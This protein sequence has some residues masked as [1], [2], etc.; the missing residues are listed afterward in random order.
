MRNN[1][2]P[3]LKK[4]TG[5]KEHP[6]E[7]KEEEMLLLKENE[8]YPILLSPQY[9]LQEIPFATKDMYVRKTVHD[10]LFMASSK[11]PKGYQLVI[12]DTWR[13]VEVQQSLFDH[14]YRIFQ[15][16]FPFMSHKELIDYTQTYVSLPTDNEDSPPPHSTGG[17]VDLSIC[18]S[19]GNLLPMGTS[20]DEMSPLSATRY[21]EDKLN[22]EGTLSNSEQEALL[23][24]RLLFDV[25]CSSGFTNYH[26]E[27][28]HFD[29]GNQFWGTIKGKNAQY[30]TV[31]WNNL[32]TFT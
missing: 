1:P 23:N 6:I 13:P 4:I 22:Q 21:F 25:M 8:G 27:W 9:F 32:R 14:Y 29:F 20:F 18:D 5:W 7:H 16:Q 30:R 24:R 28:W 11:L 31:L 15:S 19:K 17:A 26:E 12:W 3:H 2:I 10:K